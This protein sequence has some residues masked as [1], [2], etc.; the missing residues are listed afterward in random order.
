MSNKVSDHYFKSHDQHR[1]YY[2]EWKAEKPKAILIFVHGLNEHAGRYEK[3]AEYFTSQG[4]TC[5]FFDHRG[6]GRSDGLRSFVDDFEEYQKD[7]D[8]FVLMVKA[9]EKNK[10]FIIGHSMGGQIL[11]N[12]VAK[13]KP[14]IAGFVSASANIKVGFA[15]PWYKKF[16]GLQLAKICPRFKIPADVDPKWI[17][18]DRAVVLAYKKDPLVPK[19]ITL[20]LAAEVLA[21]QEALL[22]IAKK[23]TLPALIIHG[24]DDRICALEGSED[25]MKV[26]SSKDKK[27]IVYQDGYHELFNDIDKEKVLDDVKNWLSK[28]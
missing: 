17:S 27:L 28:H 6:H 3:T 25:L 22:E 21:N 1:L 26:I 14:D 10:V 23:I 9:K 20:N 19:T 4:Y 7:L 12:Y 16:L 13:Y 5:Y 8:E 15:I 24:S 18:R 11:V 2:Q